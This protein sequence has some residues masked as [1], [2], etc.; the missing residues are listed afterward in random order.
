M[1]TDEI[2]EM[3]ANTLDSALGSTEAKAELAALSERSPEVVRL[4]D[5]LVQKRGELERLRQ[6]LVRINRGIRLEDVLN[7]I[8]DGFR[9]I[10]PYNRIA[11]AAI[12]HAEGLIVARWARSDA[13]RQI[14]EGYSQPL[15]Q[16]SLME[17][18]TADR[19]RI[20]NDLAAYLADH[21]RSE[22]TRKLVAE[23][24]RSSLTCPLIVEAH[25]IGFLFFDSA[26]AGAY[27]ETHVDAFLEIAAVVAVLIERGRMFSEVAEQHAVIE[28]QSQSLERENQRAKLEMELA[29]KVQR[30]LIPDRLPDC[31]GLKL[32]MLYEPAAAV[33]G[34]LFDVI[35]LRRDAVLV[36]MADAMGHGVPAALLMSV[37]RTAFH[38]AL[39]RQ[40][41]GANPSPGELLR[42]VNRFVMGLLGNHYV[43]AVCAR[44]DRRKRRMTLSLAGHPP[45]LVRRRRT[46]EVA[47]ITAQSIPL[48][49][50]AG[51]DYSDVT[52]PFESGDILLLYTDGVTE[53]AS[54]DET[55]FGVPALKHMLQ[56][57]EGASVEGLIERL[58]HDLHRHSGRAALEDDLT[59][60][61]AQVTSL[62]W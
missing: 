10:V 52:I 50:D 48:G 32:A 25:P 39:E 46:G 30:A 6:I 45:A 35:R 49:I 31:P 41:R 7:F 26:T 59:I 5:E 1:G 53:V 62:A 14:V 36:Y 16:S 51:T 54:P 12:D 37:V 34:D 18:S 27:S 17:I 21:P 13:E 15:A 60:L 44:I 38:A 24:M 42:E 29:Q 55:D 61:A 23:G 2:A 19:P 57:W 28:Q 40:P 11:F 20:I 3:S 9:D 58:R 56:G 43:T 8:F 33:G 22:G 4:L 47:E